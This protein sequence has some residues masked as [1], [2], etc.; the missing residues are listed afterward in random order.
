MSSRSGAAE[1]SFGKVPAVDIVEKEKEYEITAELPGMDEK[2]IDVKFADGI[3]LIKGEK[4]EEKE[5][6]EK[7]YYPFRTTLRLL[8]SLVP[9]SR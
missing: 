4:S 5:E 1:L 3:L 6:K 7:D 9:G 2:N 8:P